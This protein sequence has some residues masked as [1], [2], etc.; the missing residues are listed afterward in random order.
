MQY[1][2]DRWDELGNYML[3]G[4]LE[5]DRTANRNNLVENAIRPA[6]ISRKNY[7]FAG[8][9]ESA[10]RNAIMCTFMSDCKKHNV[11]LEAWLNYVL[12][13]I[14]SASILELENLLPQNFNLR[15]GGN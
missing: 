6:A 5:I 9:H 3:D 13:K 2:F 8:T 7:L 4:L 1:T 15:D 11:N 10:Q 14:P 12:E